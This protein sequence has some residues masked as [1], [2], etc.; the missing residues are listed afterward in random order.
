MALHIV[1]PWLVM[2]VRAK[3]QMYYSHGEAARTV[4]RSFTFLR[5]AAETLIES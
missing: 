5:E 4:V 2:A 1:A 3:V